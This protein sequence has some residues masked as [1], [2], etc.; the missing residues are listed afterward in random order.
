VEKINYSPI[1]IIVKENIDY[2]KNFKF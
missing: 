2:Y 1:D